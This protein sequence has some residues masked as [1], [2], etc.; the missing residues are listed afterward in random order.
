[1]KKHGKYDS[2]ELQSEGEIVGGGWSGKASKNK[3]PITGGALTEHEKKRFA[4]M[5]K[6]VDE[7]AA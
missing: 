7:E 4:E 1:M 2:E 3:A 6:K 5:R